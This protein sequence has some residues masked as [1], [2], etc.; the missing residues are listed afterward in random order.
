M[1][2]ALLV[3]L[4]LAETGRPLSRRALRSGGVSGSNEA[5]NALARAVNAQLANAAARSLA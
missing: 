1:D 5:L 3:A 4:R 2:Q